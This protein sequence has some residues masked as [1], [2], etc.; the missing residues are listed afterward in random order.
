MYIWKWCRCVIKMDSVVYL[1]W[2]L[3][4]CLNH[5]YFFSLRVLERGQVLAA[6]K[7]SHFTD[8]Q[9]FFWLRP[10]RTNPLMCALLSHKY[11]APKSN[12]RAIADKSHPWV[13]LGCL[14]FLIHLFC[15]QFRL[16][17]Y[18]TPGFRN[19]SGQLHLVVVPVLIYAPMIYR[20]VNGWW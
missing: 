1:T 10:P 5:L 9:A 13:R 17:F 11:N 4:W 7:Q 15:Q 6:I 12:L 8:K 19:Q 3:A 20:W 14:S 18:G 2:S 16:W